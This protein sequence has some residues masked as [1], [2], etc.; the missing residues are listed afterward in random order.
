MKSTHHETDSHSHDH[1][2]EPCNCNRYEA[3]LHIPGFARP[4]GLDVP[5]GAC[6]Y[7]VSTKYLEGVLDTEYDEHPYPL[8]QMTLTFL[9]SGGSPLGDPIS[10]APENGGSGQNM[11]QYVNTEITSGIAQVRFSYVADDEYSGSHLITVQ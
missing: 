11:N 8:T 1:D 6:R 2:K 4:P 9:D 10:I 7:T 5:C 3:P